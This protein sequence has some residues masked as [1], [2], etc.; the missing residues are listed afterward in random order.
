MRVWAAWRQE[1]SQAQRAAQ[2]VRDG[3]GRL[4][5]HRRQVRAAGAELTAFAARWHPASPRLATDPAELADQVMGLHGRRVED[6][7]N[8]YIDRTVADAHPDADQIREPSATPTRPTTTPN[9][10]RANSTGS[11]TQSCA[12][13]GGPPTPP[14]P[15]ADS[16]P[17]STNWLVFNATCA[18]P[19]HVSRPPARAGGSELFPGRRS[20]ASDERWAADRLAR[21]EA[22]CSRRQGAL[23]APEE[24]T[25]DPAAPAEPEHS[26][27]RAG[28]RA[29]KQLHRPASA[30]GVRSAPQVVAFHGMDNFR[31]R[32]LVAAP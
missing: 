9:R 15:P 19:P 2:V 17:S 27:P 28:H 13:T 29:L 32:S 1:L 23:A 6:P 8:A 7:I 25:P 31:G 11:S 30:N 3:A 20:T 12:R 21:Q 16:P 14:T 10:P 26:R 5:Q 4:G 24:V 22:A 18:P